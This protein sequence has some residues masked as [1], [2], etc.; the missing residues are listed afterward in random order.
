LTRPLDRHL[1][2]D[3][4]DAL[5]SSQQMDVGIGLECLSAQAIEEAQHHVDFCEACNRKVQMH[6]SVQ[7]EMS[8]QMLSDVLS[9]PDCL[10][11]SE[12]VQVAAG[13]LP[14]NETRELMKHAAECGHCGPLLRNATETLLSD[15]T[16]IEEALLA[17]LSTVRTEW[18]T[19]MSERLRSA[20]E[21]RPIRK[22][23]ALRMK[24]LS[25]SGLAFAAV[26]LAFVAA[27]SWLGIRIWYPPSVDQ[28]LANAYTERRTLEVRVPGA[29]YAPIRLERSDGGSNLDKPESLL[30]AEALISENLRKHP[31]NPTW[32]QAKARADLLD[33]KYDSA[34]K[35]LQRA[36]ELQPDSA[37][38]LSDLGSAYFMRARSTDHEIDYGNSIELL[39]KALAKAPDDPV[40]LF[41]RALACE[42]MYLYT[43]AMDDWEHY[44]R[45][46]PHGGWASEAHDRMTALQKKINKREQSQGAPLLGPARIATLSDDS[47]RAKLDE[48]IED[49]FRII[50]SDWLPKAYTS[51][52]PPDANSAETRSA[53]QIL[54]E[55]AEQKHG[56]L[57]LRDLLSGSS[58]EGFPLA[59]DKLSQAIRANNK[60]DTASAYRYA[61]DAASLFH[62][63]NNPAGVL[64]AQL[65]RLIASNIDQDGVECG[66]AAESMKWSVD[67]RRYPWLRTQFHIEMGS[68]SWLQEA[69]GIAKLQ[70]LAASQEARDNSLDAL[71]LRSQDHLSGLEAASG[72]FRSS[73]ETARRGLAAFWSGNFPDVRG[74]NFYYNLYELSRMR[75]LPRTQVAAWRDGI[76][77][78]ESSPDIAQRAMAHLAMAN[79]AE[80]AGLPHISEVEFARASELFTASPQGNST[81]VA[82]M[83][84]KTRLAGVEARLGDAAGAIERL[85]PLQQDIEKLSDNFLAILFHT[86]LGQAEASLGEWDEAERDLQSAISLADKQ[87][88][89]LYDDKSRLQVVQQSSAAYRA[90]V[91]RQLIKG[92]SWGA[93]SLWERYRAAPL[94]LSDRKGHMIGDNESN[95]SESQNVM[96]FIPLLTKETVITYAVLPSGIAIWVA[97]DR[98]LFFHWIEGKNDEVI[99]RTTR[100]RGLCANPK[101]DRSDLKRNARALYDL[102][103]S[104]IKYHLDTSRTLVT[105]LDDRLE[106]LPFEALMDE[107]DRY[108]GDQILVVASLGIYY[109]TEARIPLPVTRNTPTLIA[110][111]PRSDAK[112]GEEA[113]PLPDALLEGEEVSHNFTGASLLESGDATRGAILSRLPDAVLFHFA[114]HAINSPEQAGILLSDA[115][116]TSA[117]LTKSSLLRLQ[118]AVFSSCDTQ[119]GPD[120]TFNN[121][122]SLVRVFLRAGVPNVVASRWNVDSVSTRQFMELFYQFLLSGDSVAAS[123]HRAQSTLRL[124]SG[125][126]H[127][128]YWSA[129]STFG[130]S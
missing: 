37:Q 87:L 91:Q 20:A 107:H 100:L 112:F 68:C 14:E 54:A 43:Q 31:D 3:E 124:Q 122:D 97:D 73:W 84:A 27:I 129:F 88:A 63:A 74:Y 33:G 40:M 47:M 78:S 53:L 18:Q 80:A 62:R 106:G 8:R 121:A 30:K 45:V 7:T 119:D 2:G 81:R 77:L 38:L 86:N 52:A 46:D 32:L 82:Q 85:K 13:L 108:F 10:K 34:V 79:A 35:T 17:N 23:T 55:I 56:D 114:G 29:E 59:V 128:Y 123:V 102:L 60:A 89:T 28:L 116:L 83:E 4:L 126:D 70:Y 58:S 103:I 117:S 61:A 93:L 92:D 72:D 65:E 76:R 1:D 57:W 50:F 111:V 26:V 12:W 11:N 44:L 16:P 109:R 39:G 75:N 42:Q 5:L 95:L 115:L 51:N 41:N 99:T 21:P 98:G 19:E 105:E 36:L 25:W 71:Y 15:A 110:A 120:D 6:K 104:P 64:R 9:G 22:L 49:Y 67:S 101:S 66:R 125:T 48:R 130:I 127:P 118:L 96:R 69:L 90:L 113:S 24:R 94:R